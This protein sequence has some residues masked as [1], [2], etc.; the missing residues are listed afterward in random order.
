M[1]TDDAVTGPMN[2]GNPHEIPVRELAERII[3]MT[4]SQ[5]PISYLP[6]PPDDPTQRCPDISYARR[7][8]GW[9]PS[10]ELEVGLKLTVDYFS[11]LI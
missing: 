9:E 3:R 6:L 5:S 10:I 2:I 1:G 8:I 7:Q 4:G 11:N